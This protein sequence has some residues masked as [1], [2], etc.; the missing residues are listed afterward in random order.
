MIAGDGILTASRRQYHNKPRPSDLSPF[1][2]PNTISFI[3]RGAK[4]QK[5]RNHVI[6]QMR[7]RSVFKMR[8]SIL[9][10]ATTEQMRYDMVSFFRL[11]PLNK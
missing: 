2:S 3:P 6:S 8:V 5:K 11:F 1:L 4:T 10:T 9:N 7:L